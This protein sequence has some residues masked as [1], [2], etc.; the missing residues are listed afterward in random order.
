M[1]NSIQL[2]KNASSTDQGLSGGGVQSE[3]EIV[4]SRLLLA[5]RNVVFNAWTDPVKVGVW[6]G[7]R[8]FRTTTAQMDVRQ[9]GTWRFVMHDPDGTDYE[10]RIEFLEVIQNEKL[11]YRHFGEGESEDVRFQTEVSFQEVA[12]DKTLLTLTMVFAT[13]KD[14]NHVVEKYG[15]IEGGIQHLDRL[16]D[17]VTHSAPDTFIISRTFKAPRELVFAV[18]TDPAHIGK[19]FGPKGFSL[20]IKSADIR[21]GGRLH[22]RMSGNGMEFWAKWEVREVIAP[23]RL[24][25]VNCFS[26]EQGDLGH[27]PAN[28]LWPQQM[29]TTVTFVEEQEGHTTVIIHWTPIHETPE[30]RAM[31]AENHDSMRGGWGGTFEQLE[32][33]L[34]EM[35][36]G[37]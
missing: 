6:W 7:P 36:T 37:S 30:S 18:W 4:L 10:N 26:D 35:G 24:I 27:H 28:P 32:A 22:T 15:A 14:R 9:G 17:F 34:A 29:L 1:I 13:A 2:A 12:K 21:P 25:F 16:G 11:V 20:M 23:E 33:Y 5:P 19:W 8:G 3:R 31:F